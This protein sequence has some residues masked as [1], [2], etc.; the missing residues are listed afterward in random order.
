MDANNVTLAPS[1]AYKA[2]PGSG[3]TAPATD[4]GQ[5]AKADRP[6]TGPSIAASAPPSTRA[7]EAAGDEKAQSQALVQ[8]T[9][10]KLNDL[11]QTSIAFSQHEETGRTVITVS[12]K[13]TGD[14][15]RSIPSED[16]LALAEHLENV[17]DSAEGLKPGLLVSSTA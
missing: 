14:E 16:F 17:L 1:A 11:A 7:A 9:L 4:T 8:E 15:I 10:R 5:Q 3:A 6:D 13:E 12:D 2:Q